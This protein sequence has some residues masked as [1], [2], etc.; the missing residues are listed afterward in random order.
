MGGGE[1]GT[2]AIFLQT[3][4][5]CRTLSSTILSTVRRARPAGDPQPACDIDV[6]RRAKCI[7]HGKASRPVDRIPLGGNQAPDVLLVLRA[8]GQ[9]LHHEQV[10]D[11]NDGN[12]HLADRYRCRAAHSLLLEAGHTDRDIDPDACRA[13]SQGQDV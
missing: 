12:E 8:S 2:G 9:G 7:G 1:S 11:R 3:A 10:L 5:E 6:D 4:D 13:V